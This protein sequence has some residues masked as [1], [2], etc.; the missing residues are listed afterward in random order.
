MNGFHR[1]RMRLIVDCE[2]LLYLVPKVAL[3]F[4]SVL[5]TEALVRCKG[6]GGGGGEGR[7]NDGINHLACL[8]KNVS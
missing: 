7:V 1:T 2:F 3:T 6:R 8:A 4:S 5:F